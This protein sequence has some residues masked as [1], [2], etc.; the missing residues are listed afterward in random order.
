MA[1]LNSRPYTREELESAYGTVYDTKELQEVFSVSS[2][3]APLVLVTRRADGVE[4]AL[5][6][7]HNP[8]FYFNFVES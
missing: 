2:F 3:L 4:G 5:L 8:R 1:E 7:T 6:F